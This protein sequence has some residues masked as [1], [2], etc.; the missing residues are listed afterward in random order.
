LRRYNP[1]FFSEINAVRILEQNTYNQCPI[2]GY[3]LT[4][5]NAIC[6]RCGNDIFEDVSSLDQQSPESHHHNIEDKQAEW[7]T[8]CLTDK[9]NVSTHDSATY[10]PSEKN[11]HLDT[12]RQACNRID[13]LEYLRN[14]SRLEIL[15]SSTT[16]KKWWNTLSADWKD[17]V[18]TTLKIVRDPSD[19][20]L[21]AF[22]ET[23]HLRCDNRRVHNLLPVRLL[24][25]L[26]HLRCDESPVEDLEPLT[27]L[28]KLQYLYAFDCDFSSLE[29]LRNLTN[30]KLLWISSTE[31]SSLEPISQL[32]NLEELYCSETMI[33]DLSPLKN[34]AK[35]QKLSCYKTGIASLEPIGHLENLIELGINNSCISDLAPLAGIKSLEYLRCNKTDINSIDGLKALAELRELS[36]ANTPLASIDALE[37]LHNLEELDIS[38]TLVTS[39]GPIMHLEQLEKI[40]LSTGRVPDEELERFIELHPDCEVVLKP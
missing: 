5:D 6:P 38:N 19:Q 34:L 27:H 36:I 28:K 24:E 29:P 23:T 39:I 14:I 15:R 11:D 7:Y 21:L 37:G 25:K 8:R 20:E 18:K 22:F 1:A 4:M 30:L 10:T 40:E 35:L 33:T 17:V 3:P 31:I 32:V 9:L 26:Q 12:V 2:C 13:E 16:R